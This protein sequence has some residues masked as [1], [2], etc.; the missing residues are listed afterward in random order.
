MPHSDFTF[1]E[2]QDYR[3]LIEKNNYNYQTN[4]GTHL[5]GWFDKR[6]IGTWINRLRDLK[7]D[8]NIVI[9]NT[10]VNKCYIK[11]S[12]RNKG[13]IG[14]VDK[15]YIK[16]ILAEMWDYIKT[17]DL[18]PEKNNITEDKYSKNDIDIDIN[19]ILYDIKNDSNS[20]INKAV[21]TVFVKMDK[22]KKPKED[23]IKKE[24]QYE[25]LSLF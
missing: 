7:D 9:E 18:S 22:K 6:Y 12:I 20:N 24:N 15:K 21:N 13:M 11:L 1:E 4:P 10:T 19:D 3:V 25:Q 5:L 23:E 2:S 14:W 17:M 8:F 16:E